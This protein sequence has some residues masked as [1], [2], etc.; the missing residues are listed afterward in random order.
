MGNSQKMIS[1]QI[2]FFLNYLYIR[3]LK[4]KFKFLKL[5]IYQKSAR[6][7]DKIKNKKFPTKK[8]FNKILY[9]KIDKI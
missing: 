1:F 2:V 9:L 5:C 4:I 7:I 6:T 8:I 3:I